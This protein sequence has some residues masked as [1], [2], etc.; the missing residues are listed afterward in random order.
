[1]SY[2]NA[3]ALYHKQNQPEKAEKYYLAAIEIY[4]RLV[5]KD[6]DAYESDL[7]RSYNNAGDF[8]SDQDHPEKAEKYYLAA[9]EIRERLVEKN[10]NAYEP[11]L[12]MSY[13]SYYLLKK[14]KTYLDKAYEIAKRR[15]DDSSCEIIVE[16]VESM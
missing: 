11:D 7:A 13:L 5:K 2:N 12:A 6:A 1:M 3:G 9:I 8:Y 14:D 10:A 15:Q 4:E 16:F